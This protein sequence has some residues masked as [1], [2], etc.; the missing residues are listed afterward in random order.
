M[1]TY[2]EVLRPVE[3][4]DFDGPARFAKILKA[5]PKQGYVTC[6]MLR[7]IDKTSTNRYMSY[8]CSKGILKRVS[9]Y[10]RVLKLDSVKFWVT[11]LNDSGHKNSMSKLGTKPLYLHSL[12]RFDEW[13]SGRQ[14]PSHKTVMA[15]GQIVRQSITKSFANV[16]DMMHYCTESDH[17]TKT[18]QRAV[19]EYMASDKVGKMSDSTY[20]SI[21]TAIKSYFNINDVVLNLPKIRKKRSDMITPSELHMTIE[22]FYRMVQNGNPSIMMRTIMNTC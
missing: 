13:L 6:E 12:A 1:T 5:L 2:Y 22:D 15:D 3:S 8:A 19:R 18:A 20:A 4:A 10:E 16:E 7:H 14:F 11:Q 17:G 21:R 9:P